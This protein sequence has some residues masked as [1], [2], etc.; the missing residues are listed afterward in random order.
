[1]THDEAAERRLIGWVLRAPR[2]AS[3]KVRHIR[4]EW[5]WA[6]SHQLIWRAILDQAENPDLA[7]VVVALDKAGALS[8]AL[9]V[10]G[11]DLLRELKERAPSWSLVEGDIGTIRSHAERRAFVA[12][13]KAGIALET[14]NL[15]T[16]DADR[17]A[18]VDS[19]LSID[20]GDG[21]GWQSAADIADDIRA[22]RERLKDEGA[23]PFIRTGVSF[24][25][26]S[27]R[28]G[29]PPSL[30][31][32]D[33]RQ[34]IYAGR[35]GSGKSSLLRQIV[36]GQLD[37]NP[38]RKAAI[39]TIEMTE[40]GTGAALLATMS[41]VPA[42]DVL[43]HTGDKLEPALAQL[44]RYGDR[45]Q[46]LTPRRAD[47]QSVRREI[48]YAIHVLG[49]TTIA[50]D[51][52]GL[53]KTPNRNRAIEL[54]DVSTDMKRLA[55]GHGVQ[56]H[57]AAQLNRNV[58]HRSDGPQLSDLR[59]TGAI[60]QDADA[61]VFTHV[62]TAAAVAKAFNRPIPAGAGTELDRAHRLVRLAKNRWGGTWDKM[63]AF[64]GATTT[65]LEIDERHDNG[66]RYGD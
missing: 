22:E 52:I 23:S 32:V 36:V 25:D 26:S 24:F 29:G 44:A 40:R 21:G 14:G 39:V 7:S 12:A 60:E 19:I 42:D 58:E 35:P 38:T 5:F 33:G 6:L 46:V 4:A 16:F 18:V 47:W 62:P 31:F 20:T 64:T 30:A 66:G 13:C 3:R 59:E 41:G 56:T 49:C 45:L 10:H 27:P 11:P 34:Y 54:G 37:A 1:M 53:I 48:E 9:G 50:V 2:V 65:F 61:I 15:S 55:S 8:T 51:Y 57:V 17:Q 28:F 43:T 63:V